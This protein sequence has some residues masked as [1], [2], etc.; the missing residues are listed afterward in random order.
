MLAKMAS[1]TSVIILTSSTRSDATAG[2]ARGRRPESE[3]RSASRG[4]ARHFR[5]LYPADSCAPTAR[6][7]RVGRGRSLGG[8]APGCRERAGPG[9]GRAGVSQLASAGA[10]G[11][12]LA[13]AAVVTASLEPRSGLGR[14]CGRREAGPDPRTPTHVPAWATL[15]FP[16]RPSQVLPLGPAL[17][18]PS[19]ARR[20][21]GWSE[22]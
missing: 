7:H 15:R 20:Q 10:A 8:G 21:W 2:E 4:T 14:G 6:A 17:P 9:L 1:C 13:N 3:V 12:L 16:T 19:Q 5:L 11:S 18:V 22:R